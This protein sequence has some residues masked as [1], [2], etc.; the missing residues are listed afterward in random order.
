MKKKKKVSNIK[1]LGVN[2]TK[3]GKQDLE[4]STRISKTMEIYCESWVMDDKT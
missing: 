1:Y 3:D 4:I 2:I